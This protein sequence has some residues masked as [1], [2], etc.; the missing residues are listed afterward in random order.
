MLYELSLYEA[1]TLQAA[2]VL[3]Q[4]RAAENAKAF[5]R[6]ANDQRLSDSLRASAARM[7]KWYQARASTFEI[8]IET[9]D[10]GREITTLAHAK[11]ALER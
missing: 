5:E 11:E 3:A 9:L 6:C 1:M 4:R 10:W 8:A 2:C 7:A